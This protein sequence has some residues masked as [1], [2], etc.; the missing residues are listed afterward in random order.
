MLDLTMIKHFFMLILTLCTFT[1]FSQNCENELLPTLLKTPLTEVITQIEHRT[2][3]NKKYKQLAAY[4]RREILVSSS[5][6]QTILDL[7]KYSLQS[8][9]QS[10]L[11][12]H[13]ILQFILKSYGVP[14]LSTE[15]D[16]NIFRLMHMISK[17]KD[18]VKVKT[19]L[20]LGDI[21]NFNIPNTDE[22]EKHLDKSYILDMLY[23]PSK[24]LLRKI[25]LLSETINTEFHQNSPLINLIFEMRSIPEMYKGQII[26][27][28][29]LKL[30]FG[31]RTILGVYYALNNGVLSNI[32]KLKIPEIV[33]SNFARAIEGQIT[34]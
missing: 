9:I 13:E 12:E 32:K 5:E 34:K 10:N 3:L 28:I 33:W 29:S 25:F 8:N 26:R 30:P 27:E 23:T 16:S 4:L 19:M 1:V 15:K 24:A 20:K 2:L 31:Q 17:E 18:L 21:Y 7:S 22:I 6:F 14:S 11:Q